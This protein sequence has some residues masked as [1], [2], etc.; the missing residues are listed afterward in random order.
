MATALGPAPLY[1]LPRIAVVP[2]VVAALVLVLALV[3]AGGWVVPPGLPTRPLPHAPCHSTRSPTGQRG[4]QRQ[5]QVWVA[6]AP[7]EVRRH[8]RR[9]MVACTGRRPPGRRP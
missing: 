1:Q 9:C 6:A 2:V 5:G 3:L 4:D 8:H 7:G